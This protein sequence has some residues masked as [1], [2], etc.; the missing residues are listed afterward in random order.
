MDY[1]LFGMQG[2]GKG[3]QGLILKK[4]FNLE[5]FETGAVLRQLAE[6]KSPLGKKIKSIIQ[7]GNLVPNEVVMETIEN[8]MK[9]ITQGKNVL[10]D[11]I[12]RKK[13]QAESFN[14]LMKRLQR[15]FKGIYIEISENEAMKR[16]S[17]RKMC[18]VCKTVYMGSFEQNQCEKCGNELIKRSDDTP[19]SI[20]MRIENYK[21]ETLPVIENYRHEEKLI[22]INGEQSVDKVTEEI[23]NKLENF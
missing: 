10:F 8:F 2:S 4:K 16:L 9:H 21:K 14:T 5:L 20:K 1:V 15:N 22:T 17:S 6:E 18:K 11:G 12:P 7:I 19:E 23:L 13:D 3:T